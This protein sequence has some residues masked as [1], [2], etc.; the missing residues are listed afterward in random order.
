MSDLA[1]PTPVPEGVIATPEQV[2]YRWE[3][4]SD[5]GRLDMIRRACEAMDQASRCLVMDH[6]SAMYWVRSHQCPNAVEVA[7]RAYQQALDDLR[8]AMEADYERRDRE[9]EAAAE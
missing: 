5:E 7:D 3:N 2:L 4:A 8:T 6:E 1:D 9:R